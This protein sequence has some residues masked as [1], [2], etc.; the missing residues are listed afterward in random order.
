MVKFD[1]F[2]RSLIQ[3]ELSQLV[4]KTSSQTLDLLVLVCI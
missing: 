1:F 2:F 4:A 3:T